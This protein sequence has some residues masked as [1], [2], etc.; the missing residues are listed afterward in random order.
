VKALSRALP[1]PKLDSQKFSE[2]AFDPVASAARG[3]GFVALTLRGE[4]AKLALDQIVSE[5]TLSLKE[6][7]M[8]AGTV[9]KSD[10]TKLCT[11]RQY[12]CARTTLLRPAAR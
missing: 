11:V 2:A 4:K 6:N 10:G 8:T 12:L 7:E 3:R 5:N 9:L 1:Y